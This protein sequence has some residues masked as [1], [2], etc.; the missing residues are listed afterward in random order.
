VSAILSDLFK[1]P[2]AISFLKASV[3]YAQVGNGGQFGLLTQTYTFYQGAGNGSIG[4]GTVLPIPNLKPELVKN[5]EGSIE[6]RF[7]EDKIG[8]MAT[9]YKSN[10]TNQLLTISLPVATGYQTQ[11][12][13]A[14]NIEN[15]GFELVVDGTPIRNRDFSWNLQLNFSLN[16]N[17]VIKLSDDVKTFDLQGDQRSAVPRVVEGGSYGDLYGHKWLKDSKGQH[18]VD[19]DGK[20]FTS[21]TSGDPVGYLG[22]FNPKENIGFTNTFTYK[23]FTL[24]LLMDGRIGGIIVSGTEMNLAFSGITKATEQYREGGLNLG[25]VLADGTPSSKTINAQ[26]FWTTAS[27]QRYGVAEFFTYSATNFRVRE[28]SIGYDIPVRSNMIKSL[29]FSAVARNLFWLYRGKSILDIP[30]L[31]KRTMWMDPDM[32][33]GNSNYQGSEYG[34]LPSTRSLGFNLRFTF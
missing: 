11:Y 8:F 12:L 16:R 22:N 20:P 33:N 29:R 3:N 5:I 17:K 6:A 2:A 4:R 32:S 34:A 18:I 25:G 21:Y 15:H 13:N 24:R 27:G 14:G 28:L 1:V 31:G 26:T 9:Y 30:G 10:S 19:A 7:F 23:G